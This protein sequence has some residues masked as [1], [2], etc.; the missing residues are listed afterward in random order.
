MSEAEGVAAEG[1]GFRDAVE[2]MA[3]GIVILQHDR[4]VYINA[5]AARMLGREPARLVG[6]AAATLLPGPPTSR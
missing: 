6:L 2:K 1:R 4:I 3:A 5:C